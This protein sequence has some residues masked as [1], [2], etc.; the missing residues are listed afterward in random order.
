MSISV[1]AENGVGWAGIV[2]AIGQLATAGAS[3]YSSIEQGRMQK[4]AVKLQGKIAQRKASLEADLARAEMNLQREMQNLQKEQVRLTM[5]L[6]R[7]QVEE[8]IAAQKRISAI[9]ETKALQKLQKS[10]ER[11]VI[12]KKATSNLPILAL[13]GASIYLLLK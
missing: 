6:Q 8:A 13:F 10:R 5:E 4:K 3:A 12:V 2:T 7:K 9:Q 1:P 11:Q